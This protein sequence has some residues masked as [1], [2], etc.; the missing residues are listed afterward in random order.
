MK[1]AISTIAWEANLDEQVVPVLRQHGVRGIEITPVRIHTD[2][3]HIRR[4]RAVAFRQRWEELGFS[5]C[6]MQALMF[7]GPQCTLFGTDHER[8]TMLH[9]LQHIIEVAHWAGA[10]VM[11]F[12]APKQRARALLDPAEAVAIAVPFFKTLGETAE[13]RGIRFCIEPVPVSSGCDF[14]TTTTEALALVEAVGCP[15]FGLH[16]DAA[17][18]T[19]AGEDAAKTL[20]HAKGKF[21][22]FHI[23]EPQLVAI[24]KGNV[25]HARM[26]EALRKTG[27][28]G[29]ASI[30][31]RPPQDATL[32][33]SLKQ[34][35]ASAAQH[36]G[37]AANP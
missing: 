12:G 35:I 33:D 26:A 5:I 29:W 17:G 18:I 37:V 27:Y 20:Q 7:G 34:G 31:M 9:Y 8:E 23:S 10:K 36:Y 19:G 24:G 30:E 1:L 11:V 6:G 15:G 13:K 22:H 25:D 4:D 3:A 28:D 21:Y 32:L 16:L 2:P 14:I